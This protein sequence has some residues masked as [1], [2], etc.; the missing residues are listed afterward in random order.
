MVDN[1]LDIFV[2]YLFKLVYYDAENECELN[3]CLGNL[4]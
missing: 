2:R 4:F 1:Y 3:I